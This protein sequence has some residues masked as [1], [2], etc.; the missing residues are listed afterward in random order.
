MIVLT[1][2]AEK[3]LQFDGYDNPENGC[4]EW[5]GELGSSGYGQIKI[6]YKTYTVTRVA[7]VMYYGIQPEHQ[8][9]HHCD[10]PLCYRKDHLYDATQSQNM[11]DCFARGRVSRPI[12]NSASHEQIIKESFY[13]DK[14]ELADKFNM[15]L[16]TLY[17][18]LQNA[19]N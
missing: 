11:K 5:L 9:C 13:K 18:I 2:L 14:Q 3:R 19:D 10:N 1:P 12:R 15:S 7:W 6:N 4:L 16:R 8:I 17:R